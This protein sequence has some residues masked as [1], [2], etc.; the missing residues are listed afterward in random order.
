LGFTAIAEF[1][2]DF[3]KALTGNDLAFVKDNVGGYLDKLD[4]IDR[5][6]NTLFESDETASMKKQAEAEDTAAATD[7]EISA[8]KSKVRAMCE[9]FDYSG[10]IEFLEQEKGNP[11][12]KN[13]YSLLSKIE[14]KLK[15]FDYDGAIAVL[16]SV[17]I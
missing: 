4:R 6:L 11:G 13:K 10:L 1:S 17:K 12:G 8:I 3:E 9:D 5:D 14:A 2:G 7:D 16:D 15:V